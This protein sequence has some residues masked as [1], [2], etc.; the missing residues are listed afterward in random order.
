MNFTPD[1]GDG[2]IT[3]IVAGTPYIIKW[4]AA[5]SNIENPVFN[6]VRICKTPNNMEIDL[7]NGKSI[8]FKGTYTKLC[9]TEDSPSI[10]FLGEN[11]TLWYPK[12]GA[13]IGA[14]RAYFELTGITAGEATPVVRSITLNFGDEETGVVPMNDVQSQK[15]NIV[16]DLQGR[17]WS[18]DQMRKGL[19]ILN[20]R[21]VVIK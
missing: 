21:K 12:N 14:Q 18:N 10:L 3:E 8:T 4:A 19:Y 13:T 2:A 16:Y 11:N 20:G 6:N 17:R 15:D 9:Y 5:N 7:G 1:T